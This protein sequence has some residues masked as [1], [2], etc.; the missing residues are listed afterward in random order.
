MLSDTEDVKVHYIKK[1][2]ML[3][4]SF[5]HQIRPFRLAYIIDGEEDTD[6]DGCIHWRD[7]NDDGALNDEA[8]FHFKT[9]K[10][11]LDALFCIA[12]IEDI[13]K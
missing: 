6:R 13:T 5:P 11:N 9:S 1:E 4:Q 10:E 2:G 3:T 8:N 7:Y 12:I